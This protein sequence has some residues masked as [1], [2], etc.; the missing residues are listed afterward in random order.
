[1]TNKENETTGV[2]ARMEL[3]KVVDDVRMTGTNFHIY[4]RNRMPSTRE[5]PEIE[6]VRWATVR[7][8][9]E[10]IF[11]WRPEHRF[12][13]NELTHI[14]KPHSHYGIH[15][16][17]GV[18]CYRSDSTK[19]V[20]IIYDHDSDMNISGKISDL[21]KD[22][23]NKT[24]NRVGLI[25]MSYGRLIVNFVEYRP[26]ELEITPFL[27]DDI[28]SLKQDMLHS[29]KTEMKGGLYLIYGKPGTGKTSFLKEILNDTD[30]QSLF[31]PPSIAGELGNPNL[32]SLLM[33]YAGSVLI[34]EDAETILM[35]READ[36]S[37]AVSN[38]LNL[39][40]GFPSDFLNLNI[41]CTFNTDIGDID[42]ALL[43]K[44][45]LKGIQEFKELDIEHARKLAETI[46]SDTAIDRKM[47][48]AE[49]CN[50]EPGF[51]NAR[52]NGIGF[53]DN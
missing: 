27:G 15:L 16:T 53:N 33:D 34:I 48:V 3:M 36:N 43:R 5:Y 40:D 51:V 44:G 7:E 29:L 42:P 35:R 6:N 12:E 11:D 37:D 46:G 30:K 18:T 1:M 47:T 23:G 52:Q 22:V 13:W 9:I 39:T 45:R 41:I 31:I 17:G 28:V 21:L 49:V 4:V 38:L 8:K 20:Q 10:T 26:Y 25:Q 2:P 32:I 50:G 24:K 14:D 19:K